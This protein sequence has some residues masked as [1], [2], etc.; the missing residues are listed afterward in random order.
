MKF[1]HVWIVFRKEIKDLL[2]DKK[3]IISSFLVPMILIPV[4]FL[5]V[6]GGAQKMEKDI[7]ENITIAL[8]QNSNTADIRKIVEDGIIKHNTNIKLINVDNPIDAVKQEKVRLVLEFDAD[9]AQKLKNDKP[10]TVKIYYDKSKNK[11]DGAVSI[12]TD[13]INQYNQQIVGQRL[14]ALGLSPDILQPAKVEETNVA[15]PGKSGNP[16][17]VMILPMMLGL[18]VTIG[19]IAAATDI[20]AGE[21][22]RNTFE[23]LLTTKPS[24]LSILTGKYLTVTLFSFISVISTGIGYVIGYMINPNSLTMGASDGIGGFSLPLVATILVF[25]TTILMGM[26]FSAVQIAISTFARSFREAQTYLSFLIFVALIPGYAT[27]F[28]QPGDVQTYMYAVPILNTI[29]AF[30]MVL[31]GNINYLNLVIALATSVIYVIL[32]IMFAASL[33]K[34]EKV[35]FRS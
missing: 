21:K 28:M 19:G 32:S 9:Y 27:M 29:S 8:S 35:L 10:F 13:A 30:K 24:R 5:F 17:L 33:F 23:P 31:G 2:R 4:I 15:E 18:L 26:T 7:S 14:T 3:T 12:L 11:S 20:V 1:R 25:I 16:T 34:K 22:E 6:G